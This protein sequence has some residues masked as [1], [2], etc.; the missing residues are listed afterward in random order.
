MLTNK[1][2]CA[3][4]A[5]IRDTHNSFY[6]F[7]IFHFRS[8]WVVGIL[9]I[10]PFSLDVEGAVRGDGVYTFENVALETHET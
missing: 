3:L 2:W 1:Q 7:H 4:S 9:I 5:L 6:L 10:L 8:R